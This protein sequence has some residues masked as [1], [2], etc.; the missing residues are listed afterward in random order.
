[1]LRQWSR[2]GVLWPDLALLLVLALVFGVR[3]LAV[4]GLD[5][6]LWGDSYQHSMIAQLLVDNGG[7]FQSWEPYTGID[8]FTYHFGFHSAVAALQWLLKMPA[9]EATLWLGQLLNG[10]AVLAIYPLAVRLTG[11]RW[12]GVW[13]V[14]LTGLLSPMPMYFTNW[15]RYTQLAGLAIL[16]AAIWLTWEAVELPRRSRWLLVMVALVVGGLALTHY[17]VLIFYVVFVVALAL[18]SLPRGALLETLLRLGWVALGAGLLF[19]PWFVNVFGGNTLRILGRT[20]SVPAAQL[21]PYAVESNATGSLDTYL[22]P[23]WWLAML[24]GLGMGLWHRRRGVLLM[25]VWLLLLLLA[26]N[27]A[28]LSLPGTGVV[29]NFAL[30]ISIY[31]LAALFSAVLV[32]HLIRPVADRVWFSLLLL[33]LVAGL[34]L[35]G[36]RE[37]LGDLDPQSHALVTY[38]DL[39]AADWLRHNTYPADRFLVNSFP[40]YGGSLIVGS[41]GGWWLPL[42]AGRQNTVPPLTYGSELEPGEPY[43]QQVE[44]LAH[45]AQTRDPDDPALLDLLRQQGVTHVYVG[46]R[47]GRVNY[48][49]P[50]L[51]DPGKLLASP[52]YRPIY[53]QDRVWIFEIQ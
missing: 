44:D 17:R 22:A 15:G 18:V 20:V 47:Q 53:H 2:S 31:L 45:L 25:A 38:P 1:M 13:A 33:L 23:V 24:L 12:G 36:A 30:F 46:Q 42:L 7:L 27:P 50:N 43:R 26:A 32:V 5:A 3:L 8:R 6:P 52:H 29:T 4:R 14:L 19:L 37:R 11:S 51:L 9:A 21:R 16:P 10:L 35:W 48:N 28:W 49:G 34:G 40:A 39:Q 41:D